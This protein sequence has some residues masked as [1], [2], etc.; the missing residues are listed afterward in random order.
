MRTRTLAPEYPDEA[1]R[2]FY[3]KMLPATHQALPNEP[4]YSD[5]PPGQAGGTEPLPTTRAQLVKLL[6]VQYGPG[7]L[8]K[9]LGTLYEAYAIPRATRALILDILA[10]VPGWS[11][12]GGVTDRAGAGHR[13]RPYWRR[14]RSAG[15]DAVAAAEDEPDGR[16]R[17]CLH[18]VDDRDLHG[19]RW[20]RV[21]GSGSAVAY[22]VWLMGLEALAMMASLPLLRRRLP[23][24]SATAGEW[25]L[26]ILTGVL[27]ML[28][29][30]LVLWAQTRGALAAV[31]AL[32]ESSVVV[33]AALGVVL[34]REPLGR[35]RI[36][37]SVA[38]AAGV[39]LLAT[40]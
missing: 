27:S 14:D 31:A 34:F 11:W 28:A 38:V 22:L 13:D 36:A 3:E 9:K 18:R 8:A 10:G 5:L 30:G 20:P 21:R 25:S 29:Y 32:R 23:R 24:P 7:A 19:P 17:R 12:R 16:R 33:A 39:V 35:T 15:A 6:D 2:R 1:S 4:P 26:A 37:A 40:G